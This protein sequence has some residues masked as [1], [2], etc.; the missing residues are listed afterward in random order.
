MSAIVEDTGSGMAPSEIDSLMSIF[1]QDASGI[2]R[3][4]ATEELD[5]PLAHQAVLAL[6]GTMNV[7]SQ[8]GEGTRVS[9]SV[10]VKPAAAND[11]PTNIG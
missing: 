1:E 3:I 4:D 9:F 7:H 10:P 5:L 8:I 2:S 11:T 6:G